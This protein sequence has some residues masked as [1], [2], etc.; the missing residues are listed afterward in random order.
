MKKTLLAAAMAAF[1]STGAIAKPASNTPP[2]SHN[3]HTTVQVAKHNSSKPAPKAHH[4]KPQKTTVHIA[5]HSRP[6][7]PPPRHH[8]HHSSLDLGDALIAFAILATAL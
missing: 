7:P 6:T 2:K 3:S 1:I 4:S 5:H 8:H